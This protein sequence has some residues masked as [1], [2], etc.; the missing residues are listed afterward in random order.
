MNNDSEASDTGTQPP[1]VSEISIPESVDPNAPG[2][3]FLAKVYDRSDGEHVGNILSED[4]VE[5]FRNSAAFDV[6][7]LE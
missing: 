6:E 7:V 5:E 4:L 2:N 3:G 1:D